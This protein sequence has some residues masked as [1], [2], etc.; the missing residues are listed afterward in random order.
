MKERN[1]GEPVP[2]GNGAFA[3][4]RPRE[5]GNDPRGRRSWSGCSFRQVRVIVLAK[6]SLVDDELLTCIELALGTD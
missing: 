3:P 5:I 4:L 6:S 2:R 1:F